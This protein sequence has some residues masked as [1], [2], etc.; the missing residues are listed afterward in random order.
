MTEHNLNASV[1]ENTGSGYRKRILQEGLVPAVVYG[2]SVGNL[3]LEVAERDLLN[4]LREGRNTII[5]LAVAGDGGPYKV[6]VKEVQYDPLKR[7]VLHVDFQQISMKEKI[8]ATVP[9][10]MTGATEFGVAQLVLR[11]LEVFCMPTD[12][13]H[14]I[15]VDLTG[16]KPGD[17]RLVSDLRVPEAVEVLTDPDTTVVTV[18]VTRADLEAEPAEEEAKEEEKA[19][20]QAEE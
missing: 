17:V 9:L 5:N 4:T 6:M 15:I 13:P 12:I 10:V 16:M 19:P 8:Q 2:K 7:N 11:D 20:E 1:R 18:T 3:L 14:E